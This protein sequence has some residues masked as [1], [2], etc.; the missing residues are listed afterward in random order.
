MKFDSV[1]TFAKKLVTKL[2][3]IS[4]GTYLISHIFDTIFYNKLISDVIVVT[5]RWIYLPLI[6]T[7]VFISSNIVSF[8][9]Y[10]IYELL[11]K[12]FLYIKSIL[13]N[14]C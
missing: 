1:S 4:F 13:K 11:V 2:S 10:Y 12:I 7:M 14:K 5:D 3:I 8:I 6:V 9:L